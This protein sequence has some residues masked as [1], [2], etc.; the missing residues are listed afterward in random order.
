LENWGGFHRE[1]N[2]DTGKKDELFSKFYPK[3]ARERLHG[4]CKRKCKA[5]STQNIEHQSGGKRQGEGGNLNGLQRKLE[6]NGLRPAEED[7]GGG[8]IRV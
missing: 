6:E 4:T 5:H 3:H 8:I 2:K 7:T 1:G